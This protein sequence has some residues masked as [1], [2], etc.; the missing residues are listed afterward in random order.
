MKNLFFFFFLLCL[1]GCTNDEDIIEPLIDNNRDISTRMPG[2]GEWDAL[3]FGYDIMGS[4][5]AP[6]SIKNSVLDIEK[7]YAERKNLFYI[8]N[9]TSGYTSYKYSSDSKEYLKELTKETKNT[10]TPGF[11]VFSGTFSVN[12]YLKTEDSYS[13]KYS[14]ASCDVVKNV[15]RVYLSADLSVLKNYLNPEFVNDVQNLPVDRI[16]E[17]YGTHVLTDFTIGG[18]MNL[19][20]K[21][22]IHTMGS[23][24]TKRTIVEAGINLVTKKINIAA[25]NSTTDEKI[26]R[27]SNENLSKE[28]YLEYYGGEGSGASYNLENGIPNINVHSWESSVN[29]NNAALTRVEWEKAYPIYEFVTDLTKRNELKLAYENYIKKN[30][31]DIIDYVPIYYVSMYWGFLHT[32]DMQSPDVPSEFLGYAI[33]PLSTP[34]NGEVPIYRYWDGRDIKDSKYWLDKN[35]GSILPGYILEYD[36]IYYSPIVAYVSKTGGADKNYVTIENKPKGPK[37]SFY[38]YK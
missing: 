2:D 31:L 11:S 16:I 15:R 33:S 5:L 22:A 28:L 32:Y 29:R 20:Y 13:G 1:V 10:I 24:E 4:Y 19:L 38:L 9:T 37:F 14:F 26:E 36:L 7:L 17:R 12:R 21:S 34:T 18:R 6:M 25:D 23:K 27:Y 30:Q 8:N 3:G 35:L